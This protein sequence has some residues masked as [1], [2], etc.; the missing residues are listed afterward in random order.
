MLK[1]DI[2]IE[3]RK[4]LLD[5]FQHKITV[6]LILAITIF[7]GIITPINLIPVFSNMLDSYQSILDF[8]ILV[9]YLS[10]GMIVNWSLSSS[11][12]IKE[13]EKIETLLTTPLSIHSVWI[14]RALAF[15]FLCNS[16][17][18]LYTI[19]FTVYLSIQSTSL[20]ILPSLV[21]VFGLIVCPLLLFGLTSFNLLFQL[22][23]KQPLI[24]QYIYFIFI[25]VLYRCGTNISFSPAPINLLI[26][27][28][29]LLLIF[30]ILYLLAKNI[31]KEKI[32]STLG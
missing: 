22:I 7:L 15:F 8:Y 14:G 5:I 1:H 19:A 13:K 26:Y 10:T 30:S 16:I 6:L 18:L 3:M 11:T 2:A 27:F 23:S 25:F 29:I 32:I 12:F 24:G 21:G 20:I 9:F 17:S 4:E 28:G 31:N